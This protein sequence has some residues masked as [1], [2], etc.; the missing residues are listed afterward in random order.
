MM[1]N[2]TNTQ[3]LL[4]Q[5]EQLKAQVSDAERCACQALKDRDMYRNQAVRYIPD[6]R[7]L[8]S[9]IKDHTAE[10]AS[11]KRSIEQFRMDKKNNQI[12]ISLLKRKLRLLKEKKAL[13]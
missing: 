9:I 4:S 7:V 5:I 2:T 3:E 13:S 10:I 1:Q 11:Y 8:D 12:E 6:V